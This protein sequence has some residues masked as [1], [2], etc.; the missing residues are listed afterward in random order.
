MESFGNSLWFH[1]IIRERFSFSI[2][3]YIL[4]QCEA[5]IF[6]WLL[7]LLTRNK[8]VKGHYL[9]QCKHLKHNSRSAV[10]FWH[11]LIHDKHLFSLLP[12]ICTSVCNGGDFYI[13]HEGW[14]CK[15]NLSA[16][17]CLA[18]N[19][20]QP[21]Q[22]FLSSFINVA[23]LALSQWFFLKLSSYIKLKAIFLGK[24]LWMHVW[25]SY[26]GIS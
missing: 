25:E 17:C 15:S 18:R 26:P 5:T 21:D 20:W 2:R 10:T 6:Q 7:T 3:F 8:W 9:C 16:Q 1:W 4:F 13:G 23:F 11:N 12:C 24:K 14:K 19:Q 22:L